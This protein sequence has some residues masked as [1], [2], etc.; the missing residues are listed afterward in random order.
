MAIYLISYDLNNYDQSYA[1]VARILTNMGAVK[2]LFSQW[3]V[4]SD[5]T[6]LEVANRVE[7]A[8][9]QDDR[10]LVVPL[11]GQSAYRNLMNQAKSLELLQL[12]S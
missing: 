9:D 1:D 4:R 10:I 2:C 3:L 11:R 8:L 5:Q 6:A 7:A 12:A